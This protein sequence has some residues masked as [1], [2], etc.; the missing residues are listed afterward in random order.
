MIEKGKKK[1]S[2]D[3]SIHAFQVQDHHSQICNTKLKGEPE[4]I[5][6]HHDLDTQIRDTVIETVINTDTTIQHDS[7]SQP[8]TVC[9]VTTSP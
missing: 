3:S 7:Y 5:L 1:N 8:F 6:K 2:W 4:E 9:R